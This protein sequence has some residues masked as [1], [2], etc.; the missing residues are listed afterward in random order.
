MKDEGRARSAVR[1][2]VCESAHYEQIQ[3]EVI[4]SVREDLGGSPQSALAEP[5]NHPGPSRTLG[6]TVSRSLQDDMFLVALGM[7]RVRLQNAAT[8]T[9]SAARLYAATSPAVMKLR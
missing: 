8:S 4:P 3:R 6:M 7:G 9:A 2:S 5:L 1:R